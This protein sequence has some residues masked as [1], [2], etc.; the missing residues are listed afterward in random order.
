MRQGAVFYNALLIVLG[1]PIW[2]A[3]IGGIRSAGEWL[4]V[5]RSPGL[6]SADDFVRALPLRYSFRSDAN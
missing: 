2:P 6:H 5:L 1:F 3:R 4:R